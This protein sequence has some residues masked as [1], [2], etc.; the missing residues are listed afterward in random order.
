MA[1]IQ[2]DLVHHHVVDDLLRKLFEDLS[3]EPDNISALI[4]DEVAKF[5]KLHN[6]S[7]RS[8]PIPVS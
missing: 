6:V 3:W 2:W 4:V 5:D 1:K 7:S 8:T